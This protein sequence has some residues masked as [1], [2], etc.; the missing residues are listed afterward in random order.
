MK[1]PSNLCAPLPSPPGEG[2]LEVRGHGHR[3]HLPLDVRPRV[4]PQIRG[5]FPTRLVG[6]NDLGS[7]PSRSPPPPPPPPWP[8]K[9][10][11]QSCL[12]RLSA[13]RQISQSFVFLHTEAS[14]SSE[15]LDENRMRSEMFLS[16]N[17][18]GC[19]NYL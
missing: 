19:V 1:C 16:F 6:R 8:I 5:A 4:H 15:A 11:S 13:Y 12:F 17:P 18:V 2:G 10:S 7:S 3:P 14:S 9:L